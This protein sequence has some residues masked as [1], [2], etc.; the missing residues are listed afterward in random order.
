MTGGWFA[1]RHFSIPAMIGEICVIVIALRCGMLPSKFISA[2]GKSAKLL[3][4][5]WAILAIFSSLVIAQD[6]AT[7]LLT[8]LRFM[9]HGLFLAALIHLIRNGKGFDPNIWFLIITA[10][11]LG[12]IMTLTAFAL[13]VPDPANFPWML[14]LPS[15]TNIRQIANIIAIPALAPFALLFFGNDKYRWRYG[16]A[17]FL[18]T[19]FIAW[20]GSRGALFGMVTGILASLFIMRKCPALR[21]LAAAAICFL[22]G[23]AAS[24]TLPLPNASFGL[25]RFADKLQA[26]GNVTSGRMEI[27]MNTITEIGRAPWAGHGAG[28][29]NA[30]MN[31]AY[32]IDF[33]HPHNFILQFT[34][35]WGVIGAASAGGLMILFM[36]A[37][38]KR[39]S[40]TPLS[41]YA[42]LAGFLTLITI[43]MVDG[44]LFYPLT[45]IMALT[46]VAPIFVTVKQSDYSGQ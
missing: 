19:M 36:L 5:V 44:A 26:P 11:I 34:Y 16:A 25:F 42:G 10:G 41:G 35:D 46:M 40:K 27:W 23:L 7:S 20:S 24:L 43:A 32:G 22:G 38:L 45:I 4:G 39:S 15:A 13:T 21:Q 8:L 9:L 33:N 18:I 14:R 28:T 31:A 17:I 29:F 12:Y 37:I 30:N 6:H 3:L 2:M 1:M